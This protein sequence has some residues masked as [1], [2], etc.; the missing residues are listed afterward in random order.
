MND[1]TVNVANLNPV[2]R[3]KLLIKLMCPPF[4][5]WEDENC[6]WG[7]PKYRHE[8]LKRERAMPHNHNHPAMHALFAFLA[9]HEQSDHELPDPV[10]FSDAWDGPEKDLW[11]PA[12]TDELASLGLNNTWGPECNVPKD[13]RLIG[14]K[15][16]FRKKRDATGKV[17]RYKARLVGLGTQN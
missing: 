17:V 10:R 12:I 1:L 15:W 9:D 14:T 7:R 3:A 13:K 6:T 4:Y 11:R 8:Q 5:W 2:E 16:V